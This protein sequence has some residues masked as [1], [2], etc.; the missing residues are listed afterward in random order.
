[1][2]V[3]GGPV[4]PVWFIIPNFRLKFLMA[5][6]SQCT[7]IKKRSKSKTLLGHS[8]STNPSNA[9]NILLSSVGIQEAIWVIPLQVPSN[10]AP[11]YIFYFALKQFSH[12]K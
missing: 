8:I 5:L 10:L 6:N 2:L 4:L 12:Y 7:V 1:M 3:S 9:R 11:A